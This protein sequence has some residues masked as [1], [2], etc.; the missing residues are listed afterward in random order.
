MPDRPFIEDGPS[1]TPPNSAPDKEPRTPDTLITDNPECLTNNVAPQRCLVWLEAKHGNTACAAAG[2]TTKE[3]CKKFLLEKNN[4]VFPGCDGQSSAACEKISDASTTGYLTEEG[5]KKTD[6]QLTS[7]VGVGGS[8]FIPGVTA[9]TASLVS[10]TTLWSAQTTP[11]Q[12]AAPA[13]MMFDTDKDGLPNTLE[14]TLGTDPNKAD[15]DGDG[16]FDNVELLGSTNPVGP[17]SLMV[18]VE[19]V[20]LALISHAPLEQ[21]RDTG[22]GVIDPTFD[23]KVTNTSAEPDS[24]PLQVG[25]SVST[26]DQIGVSFG[27]AT[28][29]NGRLEDGSVITMP[30]TDINTSG[31][32]GGGSVPLVAG[33]SGGSAGPIIAGGGTGGGIQIA[34]PILTTGGAGGGG[35]VTLGGGGGSLGGGGVTG[36]FGSS[37]LIGA[38]GGMLTGSFNTSSGSGF[39]SSI[40]APTATPKITSPGTGTNPKLFNW[41]GITD[42]TA[43]FESNTR[44][45]AGGTG[46]VVQPQTTPPPTNILSG[47]ATPNTTCLLYIYSYVPLVVP[48]KTD[49]QGRFMYNFGNSVADGQHTIYIA[50]TDQHGKI[51]KKSNP[52]SFFVK[53]AQ[54]VTKDDFIASDA[55]VSPSPVT[56]PKKYPLSGVAALVL[57]IGLIAVSIIRRRKHPMMR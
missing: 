10:F 34:G 27:G 16:V 53:E 6:Q 36:T 42:Q 31:G 54:A 17:G 35:N 37:G 26:A 46:A 11:G 15:T 21:P 3:G 41:T 18:P 30:G 1:P 29:H 5:K 56:M 47:V 28:A 8:V 22:V 7:L 23:I 49:A 24:V 38:T 48:V 32:G 45:V 40:P 9:V 14:T 33:G 20:S 13:V 50:T 4:G 2:I 25:F 12:Q 43:D 51:L 19:L 55:S 57:L 52:L 44:G 39:G